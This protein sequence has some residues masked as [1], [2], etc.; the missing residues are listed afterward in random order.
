M[1]LGQF[2]ITALADGT[3][4][5]PVDQFFTAVNPNR[6]PSLLAYTHLPYQIQVTVN[7]FL[8]NTGTRLVLIDTGTGTSQIYGPKLG[9]L[10]ANLKA[11]G[12]SAEQVLE[13]IM[14]TLEL[15]K[16]PDFAQ[17][18]LYDFYCF[19][20]QKY[21]QQP[22]PNQIVDNPLAPRLVTPFDPLIRENICER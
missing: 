17:N 1:R 22:P 10:L 15:N 12:Y 20:L 7:A 21:S 14:H 6:V 3:L 8:I 18:E 16:L 11:S 4:E 19:L 2:E 13:K 5:L 9:H